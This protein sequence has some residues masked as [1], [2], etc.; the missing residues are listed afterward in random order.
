MAWT[1]AKTAVVAVT[2]VILATGTTTIVIKTRATSG[3]TVA[4]GMTMATLKQ[5]PRIF[6]NGINNAH[7]TPN[8]IFTY[9]EGDETTHRY[10]ENMVKE[11]RKDLDPAQV[12]K[13]DRELTEQDI[14]TRTIYIYGSPE[15]HAFFQRVR[16]QLPIV[17]ETDGVVAGGR[18]C[19][20]RDVGAIFTCPN[21]V[22]PQ[23]QLVVYGTVAPESLRNLNGVFHG[24]TDY[25]VFNDTTRMHRDRSG[26]ETAEDFLLL[27]SFDK[28]DSG[29]WR[30]DE[31][32][33]LLP[34]KDLQR[35][36]AGVMVAR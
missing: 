25:V 6:S 36:T 23:N 19:L 18:K 22:N 31:S 13:S 1:K 24:P 27:G 14:Q 7:K 33:Q 30:V 8:P 20:G 34:A 29:H 21:P 32:L 3:K 26:R 5:S 35:A 17:F 16:E 4:P 28:S 12:V 11:F 10:V 9:P 15:N 2:A